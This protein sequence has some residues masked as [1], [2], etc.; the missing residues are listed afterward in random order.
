MV[1]LIL[2]TAPQKG[3]K[4]VEVREQI[5]LH[6]RFL[7]AEIGHSPH[8]A[9]LRRRVLAAGKKLRKR[10]VVR[11]VLPEEFACHEQL[12]KCGLRNRESR[13]RERVWRCRRRP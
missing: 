10:G 6:M 13:R 4:R 7:C 11:V 5:F 2:W 8:P 12:E 1:G 3:R 9:V